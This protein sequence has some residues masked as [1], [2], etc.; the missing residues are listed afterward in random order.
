MKN[1]ESFVNTVKDNLNSELFCGE[2]GFIPSQEAEKFAQLIVVMIDNGFDIEARNI[3]NF[4]YSGC[5]HCNLDSLIFGHPPSGHH[6]SFLSIK[7]YKEVEGMRSVLYHKYFDN[8]GHKGATLRFTE[9][10]KLFSTLTIESQNRFLAS[11]SKEDEQ[12][13]RKMVETGDFKIFF[14][15]GEWAETNFDVFERMITNLQNLH[16]DDDEAL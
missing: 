3:N 4:T 7:G 16:I 10:R 5:V 9:I 2:F 1:L 13:F 8:N 15:S 6:D 11:F 12:L 14:E